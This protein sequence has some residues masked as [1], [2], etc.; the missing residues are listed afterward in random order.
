MFLSNTFSWHFPCEANV[1]QMQIFSFLPMEKAQ[2]CRLQ[3]ESF[4]M[5]DGWKEVMLFRK[6][7][8]VPKTQNLL[9]CNVVTSL[10]LE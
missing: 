4:E 8:V 5:E 7:V 1:L 9:D 6:Q 10:R 3:K 2:A